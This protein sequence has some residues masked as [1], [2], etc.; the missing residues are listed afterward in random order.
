M[1]YLIDL[2]ILAT[3]V[4]T[5]ASVICNYTDTPKDDEFVAKAYKILEQFAFLNH[6]AKL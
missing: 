1:A 3:S 2:Y 5:I 4:I 6:K